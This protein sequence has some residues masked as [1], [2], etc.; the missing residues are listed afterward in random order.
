[1]LL[2][3]PLKTRPRENVRHG[4]KSYSRSAQLL[5]CPQATSRAPSLLLSGFQTSGG[6]AHRA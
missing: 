2:R 1:M 5:A 3:V 4:A 6:P